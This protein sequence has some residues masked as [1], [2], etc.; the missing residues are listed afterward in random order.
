MNL[1]ENRL[2][3]WG[4]GTVVAGL[5][6]SLPSASRSPSFSS[7]TSPADKQLLSA[8]YNENQKLFIYLIGDFTSVAPENQRLALSEDALPKNFWNGGTFI[9]N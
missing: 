8:L 1:S 9:I 2:S 4:H 7:E 5:S 6:A 3:S